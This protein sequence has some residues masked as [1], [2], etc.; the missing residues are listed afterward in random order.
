MTH[1]RRWHSTAGFV[2]AFLATGWC[3]PAP[4][5]ASSS[6]PQALHVADQV[7]S[8]LGG[9]AKWDALPGIR[10]S[11]GAEVGDSVRFLRRHAWD[12]HRGLHRVEGTNR[13]GQTYCLIHALDGSMG[14]A[15]V[16]GQPIEGDSLAKLM[17]SAM[18]MWTNDTYWMLMPYKLHDPGVNLAYQGSV[19]ENGVACDKIAL[20]F[21]D[22][23][24]TP[25]DHYW[26][27]VDRANH[28]VVKWQYVLQ[29]NEPPP[30]TW[31]WEGWEQ[32][33]GLWFATAHRQDN[34]NQ[35]TRDIETVTKFRPGEF[36]RP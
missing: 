14:K 11:F 29:G 18:A 13:A 9:K 7:M 24:L 2:V 16:A 5:H 32:H 28:R 31:T 12:M 8:A 20:S 21:D 34:R 33:S 26:V 36:E 25:G 23:G 4:G 6:D 17:K 30:V 35:F 27:Y 1:T 19:D 22:V 10:W 15:W 3:A